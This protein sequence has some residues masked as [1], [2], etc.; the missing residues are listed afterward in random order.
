[1]FSL[2][3]PLGG[4]QEV[5]ASDTPANRFGSTLIT[6]ARAIER[7]HE[8]LQHPA[9]RTAYGAAPDQGDA[10]TPA[11]SAPAGEDAAVPTAGP[12]RTVAPAVV[13]EPAPADGPSRGREPE[14]VVAPPALSPVPP[15]VGERARRSIPQDVKIAVSARDGGRCRQCGSTAQLHFDHVIPISRGGANTVA[16]IQLL[17]GACNRAKGAKMKLAAGL[18]GRAAP[19]GGKMPARPM[20]VAH[21]ARLPLRGTAGRHHPEVQAC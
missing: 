13:R 18:G 8:I 21:V 10:S 19:R 20:K 2:A 6:L 5:A 12:A 17:C 15:P 7:L 3:N 1:M 11:A 14:P 9:V 16:N 4:E